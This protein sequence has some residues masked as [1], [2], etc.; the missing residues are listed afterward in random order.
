VDG[1]GRGGKW[2]KPFWSTTH[3]DLAEIDEGCRYLY[4]S[5]KP[6]IYIVTLSPSSLCPSF[7]PPSPYFVHP[8]VTIVNSYLSRWIRTGIAAAGIRCCN[9]VQ[10]VPSIGQRYDPGHGHDK[11]VLG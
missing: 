6:F 10:I 2:I 1:K 9:R 7:L 4:S 3:S 11:E 5:C 8:P